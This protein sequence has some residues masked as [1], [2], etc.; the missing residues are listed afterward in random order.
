LLLQHI[1]LAAY[2][3]VAG[4]IIKTS[5]SH[6]WNGSFFWS[7]PV[8]MKEI[9]KRRYCQTWPLVAGGNLSEAG[10]HVIMMNVFSFGYEKGF[11][12]RINTNVL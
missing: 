12:I 1:V 9:K 7:K 3:T 5:W 4:F 2:S 11:Y 6:H 10:W 8:A